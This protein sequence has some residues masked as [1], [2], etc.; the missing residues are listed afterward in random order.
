[1]SQFEI[2]FLYGLRSPSFGTRASIRAIIQSRPCQVV[3]IQI[4]IVA[5]RS[6]LNT[7]GEALDYVLHELCRRAPVLPAHLGSH[8]PRG[9]AVDGRTGPHVACVT[10]FCFAYTH[11]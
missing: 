2:R 8:A 10:F 5:V 3:S 9:S 7:L 6:A 4:G 1:M 11:N